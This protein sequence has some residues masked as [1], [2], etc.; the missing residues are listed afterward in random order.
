M[1][2]RR[3]GMVFLDPWGRQ[4][5]KECAVQPVNTLTRRGEK[6]SYKQLSHHPSPPHP[7][8]THG[9]LEEGRERGKES[10]GRRARENAN[11]RET[12]KPQ[13][14]LVVNHIKREN[15]FR[16]Q[17]KLNTHRNRWKTIAGKQRRNVAESVGPAARC[18]CTAGIL[19]AALSQDSSK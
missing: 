8:H 3:G 5:W 14:M 16:M 1:R 17:F 11:C 19:D 18:L 4:R 15:I 10:N 13:N 2:N 6:T 9:G 12:G 7:Q